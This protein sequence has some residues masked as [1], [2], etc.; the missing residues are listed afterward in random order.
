MLSTRLHLILLALA[1]GTG[2]ALATTGSPADATRIWVA[3]LVPTLVGAGLLLRQEVQADRHGREASRERM[4]LDQIM[5]R[6]PAAITV[7]DPDGVFVSANAAAVAHYGAAHAEQIIGHAPRRDSLHAVDDAFR[8]VLAE[9]TP[10]DIVRTS[11]SRTGVE[12][13]FN[14]TLLPFEL[15]DGRT[16]VLQIAS[17]IT[18]MRSVESRLRNVLTR[19]LADYIPMCAGCRNVRLDESPTEDDWAPLED[20]V[21]MQTDSRFSHTF[22]P[23]CVERLYGEVEP[24]PPS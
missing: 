12:T 3:I 4:R 19:A 23:D 9:V 10:V 18:A 16:G 8:Q 1:G 24:E 14:A 7:Q 5:R 11:L 21:A 2:L 6:V 15:D 17:D 20:Y 13:T 22:C